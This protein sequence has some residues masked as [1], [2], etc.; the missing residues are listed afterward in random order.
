MMLETPGG[1]STGGALGPP[2]SIDEQVAALR[3]LKTFLDSGWVDASSSPLAASMA[4]LRDR[5]TTYLARIDREGDPRAA[6]ESLEDVLLSRLPAQI[7]RLR[8]AIATN[9]VGREDLPPALVGRML[10]PTGQARVQ[11]FPSENLQD[12]DALERFVTTLRGVDPMVSGVSINL[13][14]FGRATVMSFE[15]ALTLAVLLISLL[16]WMLWRSLRDVSLALAPLLLSSVFTLAAMAALGIDFNFANVIVLPLL[17]G[18]GVDS[19]IHLVHRAKMRRSPTELL[20]E[21]TTARAVFYSALT[22]V[23]SFGTLAF[24]AHRGVASL[25]VLL[26]MGMALTIVCNLIVLPALI[27]WRGPRAPQASPASPASKDSSPHEPTE[28]L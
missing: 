11:V 1:P 28:L 17:L 5:L 15:R 27:D 18:I 20:L 14:D 4:L 26:T 7:G 23:V 21:T 8:E 13:F 2:P 22:T 3:D 24:S 16:L 19:G 6:L 25:G 9:G 10:A 12:G